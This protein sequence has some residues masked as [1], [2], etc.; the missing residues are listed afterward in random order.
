MIRRLLV[1]VSLVGCTSYESLP[2]VPGEPVT[3]QLAPDTANQ[4]CTGTVT[5]PDGSAM[6]TVVFSYDAQ[7]REAQALETFTDSTTDT[8]NYSYDNLSHVI[9]MDDLET[10]FSDVWDITYD[11]LGDMVNVSDTTTFD[12]DTT[13]FHLVYSDFDENGNPTHMTSDDEPGET[14]YS[15][16]SFGRL[17]Y[18]VDSGSDGVSSVAYDEDARVVTR[19]D[20]AGGM[21]VG[22]TTTTYDKQNRTLSRFS[23]YGMGKGGVENDYDG[24]RRVSQTL[25]LKGNATST[26]TYN[27]DCH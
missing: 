25:Y 14:T 8:S 9:H 3:V 15:Y 19:Y 2:P 16:D 7:G 27:Y 18:E 12:T 23:D 13:S 5:A 1:C 26:T 21:L 10:G 20:S 11:S 4:P 6:G 22:T 24:D 17:V